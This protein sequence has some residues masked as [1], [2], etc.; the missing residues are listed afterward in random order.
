MNHDFSRICQTILE[1]SMELSPA[2]RACT[3]LAK[4]ICCYVLYGCG[5]F[6]LLWLAGAFTFLP[7]GIGIYFGY[8]KRIGMILMITGGIVSSTTCVVGLLAR[9][10]GYYWQE[11]AIQ[12]H[13]TPIPT[14]SVAPVTISI[15]PQP[16]K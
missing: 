9:F 4:E 1:T 15:E 7:I 12:L 11:Q 3:L 8:D 13:Q 6:L 2:R 10:L 16:S 14:Q 5:Y